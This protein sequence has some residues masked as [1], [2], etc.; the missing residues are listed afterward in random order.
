MNEEFIDF[1]KTE[2]RKAMEAAIAQ[3]KSQ[4]GREYPLTIGGQNVTT[5]DKIMSYNPSKPDQIV[6]IFQKATV[7]MANQAVDK[8]AAAFEHW[9]R[10]PVE[11]RV[12]CLYDRGHS[13]QTPPRTRCMAYSRNRKDL[14]GSR[15]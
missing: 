2:N 10:V 14:A 7:A 12:A 6:S 15:S 5:T 8:A 3:V 4:L 11:E 9:K 13:P 1:S